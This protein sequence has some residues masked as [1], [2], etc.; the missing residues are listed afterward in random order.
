MALPRWISGKPAPADAGPHRSAEVD[1]GSQRSAPVDT[2]AQQAPPVPPDDP[3]W[4]PTVLGV[5]HSAR[6][7]ALLLI[8]ALIADGYEG[9]PVIEDEMETYHIRLC[10][11]REWALVSWL[12]ICRQLGPK[13]F[14]LR[15]GYVRAGDERWTTYDIARPKT[16]DP[17]AA[18][19]DIAQAKRERGVRS[20]G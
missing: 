6:E 14:N 13:G 2:S 16:A 7:R 20:D 11:K 3:D 4:R 19:V 1:I 12:G 15:K 9:R 8:D 10:R 18:V 5:R 17:A